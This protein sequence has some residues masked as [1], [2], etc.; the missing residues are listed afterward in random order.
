MQTT[1]KRVKRK[2]ERRTVEGEVS[3]C[4]HRVSWWVELEEGMRLTHDDKA[5]LLEEVE[6][7]AEER[8]KE[9]IVEGY[10]SG[11]LIHHYYRQRDD[12]EFEL[13]GW[14][15]IVQN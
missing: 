14:W 12:K 13:L 6:E 5:E 10:V 7:A 15:D 9:C 1:I 11:Q 4:A 2:H 3:V 8:A